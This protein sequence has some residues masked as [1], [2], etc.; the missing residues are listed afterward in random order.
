LKMQYT[1]MQQVDGIKDRFGKLESD[2][3]FY[4]QLSSKQAF[5]LANRLGGGHIMGQPAFFQQF[6]IGGPG[7]LRGYAL[8]R[9]TGSSAFYHNIEARIKL[10]DFNS[11]LFPGTFGLTGFH[12]IGRVWV[13]NE[14][15]SDWH[16]GYGAGLFVLPADALVIQFLMGFSKEG[17]QPY[18]SLGMSF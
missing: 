14:T 12:D 11:Y 15:S 7:N 13:D 17:R 3:V 2:M 6:Q 16:R 1:G 9:F 4:L 18:L 5:V 8:N 10:F